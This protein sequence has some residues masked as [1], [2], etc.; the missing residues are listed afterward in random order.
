MITS[1]S[2]HN[3]R[4]ERLW[5]DLFSGCVAS[6]YYHFEDTGLRGDRRISEKEVFDGA[7]C[8]R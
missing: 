7:T 8:A 1:R 5:R 4:I 3:Q 2:V 6:F